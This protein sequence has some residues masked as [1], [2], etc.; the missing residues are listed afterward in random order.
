MSANE[1]STASRLTLM[2]TSVARAA[3]TAPSVGTTARGTTR[4][5][6]A[7]ERAALKQRQAARD[8]WTQGA[9][10]PS[11]LARDTAE[12]WAAAAKS[13]ASAQPDP[14]PP[15]TTSGA[16]TPNKCAPNGR[17]KLHGQERREAYQRLGADD[18]TPEMVACPGEMARVAHY[19]NMQALAEV[20]V[21][22]P[23]G[24]K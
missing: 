4:F 23:A 6:T 15:G 16:P 20:E 14:E 21:P 18:I 12:R 7:A 10:K 1:R 11:A 3:S 17:S 5:L 24:R 22:A 19:R 13:V 9:G 8:K 2:S